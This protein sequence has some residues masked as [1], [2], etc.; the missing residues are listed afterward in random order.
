[1]VQNKNKKEVPLFMS[2]KLT[3][4]AAIMQLN[5]S[6]TEKYFWRTISGLFTYWSYVGFRDHYYFVQLAGCFVST[7]EL[8]CMTYIYDREAGSKINKFLFLYLSAIP[9]EPLASID[10]IFASILLLL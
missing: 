1:M 8:P 9:V 5:L 3:R 4:Q 6:A 10:Y 2:I 7:D